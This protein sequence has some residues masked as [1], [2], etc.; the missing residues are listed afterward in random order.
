MGM[1]ETNLEQF[2]VL[3]DMAKFHATLIITVWNFYLTVTLVIVGWFITAGQE[4]INLA[5]RN[6]RL[7]IALAFAAFTV[8]NVVTLCSH[9]SDMDAWIGDTKAMM[10]KLMPNAV[11]AFEHLKTYGVTH[12]GSLNIDMPSTVVV[13]IVVAVFVC[14]L[15]MSFGRKAPNPTTELPAQDI[16][17]PTQNQTDRT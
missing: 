10:P 5:G 1:G 12:I 13:Q 2:K 3:L 17:K 4:K 14:W 9:Y 11:H 15:I 16:P 7:I 8:V 6:S